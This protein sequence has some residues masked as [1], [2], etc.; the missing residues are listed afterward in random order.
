MN[1]I[2]MRMIYSL[3]KG[4]IPGARK[5]LLFVLAAIILGCAGMYYTSSATRIE[6]S[7]KLQHG[8]LVT[9]NE[10][11]VQYRQLV[12]ERGA[13]IKTAAEDLIPVFSHIVEE[14]GMRD[15]LLQISTV[16]RGI[17]VQMDRLYAEDLVTILNGL[18]MYGIRVF[19]SELRAMP[20]QDKRLF[21]FQAVLEAEN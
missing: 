10:L 1:K 13:D 17:S 18:S 11:A 20:Y 9:L 2:D 16:S 12:R 14:A 21:I 19:S 8:R 7:Y 5:T 3:I 15:R 6:Q 4:E